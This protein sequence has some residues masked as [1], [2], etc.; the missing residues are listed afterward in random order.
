MS[1]I[2]ER[3]KNMAEQSINGTVASDRHIV[4]SIIHLKTTTSK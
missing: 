2:Q 4:K 1:Y 3:G